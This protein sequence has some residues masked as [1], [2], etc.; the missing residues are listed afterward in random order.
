MEQDFE[1]GIQHHNSRQRE[2]GQI[3]NST[4]NISRI[5]EAQLEKRRRKTNRQVQEF[6]ISETT[7]NLVDE[8]IVKMEKIVLTVDEL[9]KVHKVFGNNYS[10]EKA[11][12]EE[13]DWA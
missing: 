5:C 13:I 2:L 11:Y 10:R 3:I 6:Q 8:L 4:N 9:N 1:K 12:Q 7:P